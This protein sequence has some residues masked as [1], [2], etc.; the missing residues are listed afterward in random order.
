M[1]LGCFLL[2]PGLLSAANRPAACCPEPTL[3][4]ARPRQHP[5][6]AIH[7]DADRNVK[8][9]GT[10]SH[11]AP[12]EFVGQVSDLPAWRNVL[13]PPRGRRPR[14]PADQEVCPTRPP[15]TPDSRCRLRLLRHF[16][17]VA[18]LEPE[19]GGGAGLRAIHHPLALLARGRVAAGDLDVATGPRRSAPVWTGG[20]P[21]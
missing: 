17:L 14:E 15:A 20:G 7:I 4:T 21:A 1:F 5:L 9:T 11:H 6:A 13:V 18:V 19:V 3:P 10:C 16:D 12:F 8:V 2:V